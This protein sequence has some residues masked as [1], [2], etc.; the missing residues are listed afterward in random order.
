MPAFTSGKL[1]PQSGALGDVWFDTA[2]SEVW[3]AVE[4]TAG[5]AFLFYRVE[6]VIANRFLQKIAVAHGPQG[7]P[8]LA[9]RDGRNAPTLEEITASVLSHLRQP[10]DG[11]RGPQGEQGERG[12]AGYSPSVD[13]IVERV[14]VELARRRDWAATVA[15]ATDADRAA[16]RER[17]RIWRENVRF[18]QG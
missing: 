16:T 10:A 3:V 9:G 4:P 14:L 1:K 6:D 12:E 18:Q 15:A 8:G 17:A 2:R 5:G 11:A 13:E 7:E